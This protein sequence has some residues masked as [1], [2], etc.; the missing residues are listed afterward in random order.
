MFFE[1]FGANPL[2]IYCLSA[3]FVYIFG[4]IRFTYNEV[5]YNAWSFWYKECMQPL[6]GDKGGS[7]ACALSLVIIMW[8]I[9]HPLYRKHIYIKI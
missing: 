5:Q 2:F 9:A 8:C 6:F 3:L 4:A 7:L 1:S